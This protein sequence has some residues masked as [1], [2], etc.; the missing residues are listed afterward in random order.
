MSRRRWL[1]AASFVTKRHLKRIPFAAS[2][3]EG[4]GF[5]RSPVFAGPEWYVLPPKESW[6]SLNSPTKRFLPVESTP[7]DI[8]SLELTGIP[9][10]ADI[11]T[12]MTLADPDILASKNYPMGVGEVADVANLVVFLLSAKA[13]WITGQNYVVDCASF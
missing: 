11:A 10:H 2:F 9:P 1:F 3:A 6:M 5:T 7:N 8:G 4:N 12:P 13:K